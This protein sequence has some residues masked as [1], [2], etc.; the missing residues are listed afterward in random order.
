MTRAMSAPGLRLV[1]VAAAVVTCLVVSPAGA[2]PL[3]RS[4]PPVLG[5]PPAL[6]LPH[7]QVQRLPNGLGLDVLEMHETPVV[8]LTFIIHAGVVCDP[9]DLPGLA[10]FTA[11]MLDE[12]AGGKSALEIAEE[13][14]YLGASFSTGAGPEHAI[15]RLHVPRRQLEA[16]LDLLADVLL[17]PAFPDSEVARRRELR[18]NSI[19]QLRDQP[20]AI[21]PIAFGAIVYGST[22]PFGR[23]AEGNEASTEALTREKVVDFYE[24]WYRPNNATLL[25]VGDIEP[26]EARR[27]LAARFGGWEQESLPERATPA[28]PRPAPRTFYLVDKPDAPQSVIRIGHVGVPRSTPDYYALTVMNTILGGSFTSRLMQ[29]LRETHGY[30]YG[31]RSRFQMG[32]LAGPFSAYAS[33]QTAKTDSAVIEFLK[34]LRRL[35]DEPVPE[36]ELEKAKA[37]LALGLPGDF[38]T[39]SGAARKFTDLIATD[40]PLDTYDQYILRIQAV[41]VEDV[42]RV[43]RRHILDDHLAMV[44]VGDR[45]Q[46]EEGLRALEEG[47]VVARDLWGAEV[48]P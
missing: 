3:D 24:T 29:N 19:L 34:E 20:L 28:D 38:E 46:I 2:Q 36:A 37:Y 18:L 26:T 35:R 1:L 22:H 43:A 23:P 7:V 5:A 13:F 39:T 45:S 21:S 31:A 48:E 33:V 44:I 25:V 9:A 16:A 27:L 11:D 6:S 4:K 14:E 42:Q 30:T 8:D 41:T 12:G 15:V 32:R 17:R 47:P 10:T 40:L